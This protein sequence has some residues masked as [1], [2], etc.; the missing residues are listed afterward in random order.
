MPV[1]IDPRLPAELA[2]L[3]DAH[4]VPHEEGA[5]LWEIEKRGWY[6][7]LEG[8]DER[9]RNA[10]YRW[11]ARV[12]PQRDRGDVK[13]VYGQTARLALARAFQWIVSREDE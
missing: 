2:A 7:Q 12:A 9:M 10:Q 5:L 1:T 6:V 8:P 3:L 4:D 11:D 13:T